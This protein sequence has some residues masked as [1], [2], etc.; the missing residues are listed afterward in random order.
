MGI[1]MKYRV[2]MDSFEIHPN[3]VSDYEGNL[4]EFPLEITNLAELEKEGGFGIPR[5]FVDTFERILQ[6]EETEYELRDVT[7]VPCGVMLCYNTR[8]E[9]S[10]HHNIIGPFVSRVT[11]IKL[12]VGRGIHE[13]PD[14]YCISFIHDE[15][16]EG[17]EIFPQV[18]YYSE[19][20]KH[21]VT[22]QEDGYA[23][24]EDCHY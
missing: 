6:G 12:R 7:L 23:I 8:D 3:R 2:L 9:N 1:V 22:F 19:F 5:G 4:V 16:K 17:D 24:I 18:R 20:G 21:T 13:V 15:E 11:D 14:L 10:Y